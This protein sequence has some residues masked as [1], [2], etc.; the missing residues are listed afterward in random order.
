MS[1]CRNR[2]AYIKGALM[3]SNTSRAARLLASS[4]VFA[5]LACPQAIAS[6]NSALIQNGLAAMKRGDFQHSCASFAT[7]AAKTKDFTFGIKSHATMNV[8]TDPSE[9]AA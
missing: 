2:L 9:A 6:P 4:A 3:P 5:L 1:R 7:A 8:N